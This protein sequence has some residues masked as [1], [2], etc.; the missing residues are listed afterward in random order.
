MV[1]RVRGGRQPV[2]EVGRWLTGDIKG[3]R[4]SVMEL[5]IGWRWMVANDMEVAGGDGRRPAKKVSGGWRRRQEN[6]DAVLFPSLVKISRIYFPLSGKNCQ[7]SCSHLNKT[8]NIFYGVR[9]KL[10]EYF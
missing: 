2:A 3:S 5:A 8:P 4:W 7:K 9:K 10:V 6:D 1:D